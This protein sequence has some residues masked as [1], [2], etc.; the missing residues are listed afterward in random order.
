VLP[1]PRNDNAVKNHYH[2]R[3]R[4]TLR[5]LNNCILAHLRPH[6]RPLKNSII[7]K[8]VQTAEGLYAQLDP[9]SRERA[10]WA[11]GTTFLTQTSR[12]AFLAYL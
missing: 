11:F 4:K 9:Q 3:F 2:S 6:S 1:S 5:K 10:Q 12:T 8:I 7:S